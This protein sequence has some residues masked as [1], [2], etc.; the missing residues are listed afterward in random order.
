MSKGIWT[1]QITVDSKEFY[2]NAE[3]CK[4]VWEA[5]PDSVI[6]EA[7]SLV[8]IS[9]DIP[10]IAPLVNV[11]VAG[12]TSLTPVTHGEGNSSSLSLVPVGNTAPAGQ[13]VVQSG[14]TSDVAVTRNKRFKTGPPASGSSSGDPS[15]SEY[16][17]LVS[18]IESVTGT[19][20]EQ[21]GKWLV[22]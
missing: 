10:V 9:P 11:T 14:T 21:G 2:Y 18:Q 13:L 8:P 6:H 19:A 5:P 22:R 16:Q 17:K 15:V 12:V 4:S 7:S 20:S 1:K 3:Q